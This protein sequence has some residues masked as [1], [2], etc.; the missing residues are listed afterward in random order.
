MSAE[1][2][3]KLAFTSGISTLTS[4]HS[5]TGDHSNPL[6]YGFDLGT[7]GAWSRKDWEFALP[8]VQEFY[9]A[10]GLKVN[11]EAIVGGKGKFTS[12]S[13]SLSNA[14]FH[15]G[16]G[17]E[18][19]PLNMRNEVWNRY[20]EGRNIVEGALAEEEKR[21]LEAKSSSQTIGITPVPEVR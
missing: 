13:T 20:L 2:A 6:G 1:K 19:V 16:T 14:H 4:P 7:G 18:T 5:K 21:V 3:N 17:K 10:G 12:P 15:V 11:Y 8:L 9:G